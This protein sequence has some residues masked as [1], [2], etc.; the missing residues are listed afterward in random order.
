MGCFMISDM[1][2]YRS[3]II[4]LLPFLFYIAFPPQVVHIFHSTNQS[5]IAGTEYSLHCN[6][7]REGTLSSSTYLEIIWLDINNEVST[8]NSDTVINGFTNST[9]TNITS[10]LTF[11][12]IRTSQA[13]RYTCAVNMTIPGVVED[14]QVR[15]TTDV[16]V[17]SKQIKNYIIAS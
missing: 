14:R 1:S 5:T 13:G 16:Y 11:P 2:S 7:I 9:D 10:T 6:V 4:L 12:Y 17:Q 15:R 3:F 8:S